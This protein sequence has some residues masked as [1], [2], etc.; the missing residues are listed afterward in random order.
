MANFEFDSLPIKAIH[1]FPLFQK[2]SRAQEASP[3][4]GGSMS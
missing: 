3:I 2:S 4:D 1:Y